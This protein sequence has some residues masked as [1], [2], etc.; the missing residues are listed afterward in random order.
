M[1][2]TKRAKTI[3]EQ[4]AIAYNQAAKELLAERTLN[5]AKRELAA[6]KRYN[7][8]VLTYHAIRS[9]S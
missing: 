5:N 7:E 3:R 9:A 4:A 2:D 8:T 6:W 1:L